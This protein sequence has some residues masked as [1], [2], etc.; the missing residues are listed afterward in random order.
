MLSHLT[1]R[2]L[3]GGHGQVLRTCALR[4]AGGFSARYWRYVLLDHEI[5]NRV[6]RYG[7]C[8]YDYRLWC[9]PSRRRVDRSRVRWSIIERVLYFLTPERLQDWYFYEFLGPRLDRR[10]MS[11]LNLRDQPWLVSDRRPTDPGAA[12]LPHPLPVRVSAS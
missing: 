9:R 1:R 12:G 10:N 6:L 4:R 7:R 3:V 11:H 2:A 8:R 5:I